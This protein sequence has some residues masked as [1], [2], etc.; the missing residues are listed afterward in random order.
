MRAARLLGFTLIEMVATIVIIGIISVVLGQILF[1]SYATFRTAKNAA[2]VDWQGYIAMERMANDIHTIRSINDITS[3]QSTQLSFINMSNSTVS[4]Q[5]SGAS[6]LRNSIVLATGISSFS[7]AYYDQNGAV[8][9]TP[10][11]I[12]YIA[13]SFVATA[14]GISVGFATAVGTRGVT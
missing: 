1:Q 10:S 12:R 11:A 9:S 7:F 13:I 4:Y 14:D 5:F 8:T 3:A 2:M 6:L